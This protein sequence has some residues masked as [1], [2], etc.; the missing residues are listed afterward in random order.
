M[1]AFKINRYSVTLESDY[2]TFTL[3]F[4][5]AEFLSRYYTAADNCTKYTS[6]MR[7]QLKTIPPNDHKALAHLT[8]EAGKYIAGQIDEAIGAGTCAAVFGDATPSIDACMEF[9]AALKPYFEAYEQ[10]RREFT[11]RYSADRMGGAV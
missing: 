3:P 5:D 1:E 4:D 6:Q 7:E 11:S 10:K 2:G 9:F 8:I